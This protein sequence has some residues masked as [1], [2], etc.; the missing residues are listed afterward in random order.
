MWQRCLAGLCSMQGILL[1]LAAVQSSMGETWQL[2]CACRALAVLCCS[3]V[4]WCNQD[5]IEEWLLV[6]KM[7]GIAEWLLA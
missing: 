5:G 3:D 2:S 7:T 1:L 6:R 4:L